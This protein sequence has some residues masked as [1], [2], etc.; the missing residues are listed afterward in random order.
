M[1]P[2]AENTLTLQ[3]TKL[4]GESPILLIMF[5]TLDMFVRRGITFAR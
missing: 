4:Q 2:V 5:L 1:H 3:G